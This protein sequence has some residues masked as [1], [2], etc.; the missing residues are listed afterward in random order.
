M[1]VFEG[2]VALVIEGA[3]GPGNF[4]LQPGEAYL[5]VSALFPDRQ[6]VAGFRVQQ[7]QQAVEERQ[8][9]LKNLVETLL[10]EIGVFAFPVFLK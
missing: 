4:V 1:R 2:H 3:G 8:G 6:E 9:A 5:E 7:E 10:R